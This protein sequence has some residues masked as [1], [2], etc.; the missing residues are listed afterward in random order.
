MTQ[1]I[2]RMQFLRGDFRGVEKTLRPP[3]AVSESQFVKL[4][5]RCGDCIPSCPTSVLVKGRA[6]FPVVDFSKGECEFCG[7]CVAVCKT[8]ALQ[9]THA[10]DNIPWLLKAVIDDSCITYQGVICRSCA[11]QCDARAIVF[12]LVAGCVPRPELTDSKCT[13]CGACV[14]I[15]PVNA[16]SITTPA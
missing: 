11:E 13:G 8:G 2:S 3:W 15:C 7:H 10:P 14:S 16:I 9:Q 12:G 6:G 4:C 5:N 1:T